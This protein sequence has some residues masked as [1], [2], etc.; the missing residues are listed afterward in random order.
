[1]PFRKYS[2]GEVIPP[3]DQ[4]TPAPRPEDEEKRDTNER[5]D[6]TDTQSQQR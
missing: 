4:S 1:M 2:T 6:E 3:D 5:A